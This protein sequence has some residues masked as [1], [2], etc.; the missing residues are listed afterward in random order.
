MRLLTA[1]AARKRVVGADVVELSPLLEGHTS[2]LLAA[3]LAYKMVGLFV[4][5]DAQPER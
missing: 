4:R 3:K 2:P 1:V 5:D